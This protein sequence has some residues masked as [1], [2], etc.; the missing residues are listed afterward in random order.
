MPTKN[1]VSEAFCSCKRKFYQWTRFSLHFKCLLML[2]L[3]L[4][5]ILF[6]FCKY[7]PF[8]A[9]PSI[10][11]TSL[12]TVESWILFGYSLQHFPQINNTEFQEFLDLIAA[13]AYLLHFFVSWIFATFLYFYY[14]KKTILGHPVIQPYSYLWC[15]GILNFAAVVTQLAWP[16][17]PP[18]YFETYGTTP[19][20]YTLQGSPA[21]LKDADAIIKYPLFAT[22]YGNSPIVF[23]SFPSL[24]A[25]WPIM[26]T[27]FTPPLKSLKI[28]G[29][30]YAA[31]VWWAALYLN[32][33]FLVDLLGGLA[34]VIFS[35]HFG[36]LGIQVIQSLL[37]ETILSPS[38]RAC[39]FK[40]PTS[41]SNEI[42]KHA[43]LEIIDA[44][45]TYDIV[46]NLAAVD[47]EATSTKRTSVN[48]T[49]FQQNDEADTA[50]LL[51]ADSLRNVAK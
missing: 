15:F 43:E 14:R 12:P 17:A 22:V 3:L 9:R 37:K 6:Q 42:Y 36:M 8:V 19:A 40:K 34:F 4:W 38:Q 35:Y 11:V 39:F 49:Y 24:H 2:P 44:E 23:G 51:P 31:I 27:I 47:E 32:H 29:V 7:L 20:N 13:V 25:A 45:T 30:V 21:G 16:T 5:L 46:E 10:D 28:L 41:S 1:T 50:S 18:W 48:I 33:H 26:I